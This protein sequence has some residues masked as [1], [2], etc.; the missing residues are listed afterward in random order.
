MG[1]AARYL[2]SVSWGKKIKFL[3]ER[4][5]ENHGRFTAENGQTWPSSNSHSSLSATSLSPLDAM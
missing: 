1:L 3:Q 2:G 4:E 5:L